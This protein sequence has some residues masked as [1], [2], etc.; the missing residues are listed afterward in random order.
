MEELIE[1][2]AARGLIQPIGVTDLENG[3]YKIRWGMRRTLA[4]RHLANKT[5][6]AL[7]HGLTEGDETDDMARENF[8]R[9]QLSDAEEAR[10]FVQYMQEKGVSAS[11]T[12][13]RL[14]VSYNKVLRASCIM[15]GD[16]EVRAAFLEGKIKA[17]QAVELVQV[18]GTVHR[19]NML[20]HAIRG[21]MPANRLRLWREQL[22]RDGVMLAVEH[23]PEIV[24][25][26]I[27]VRNAMHQQCNNCNEWKDVS[28]VPIQAI[29]NSCWELLR[30][31]YLRY[32]E[33][34]SQR[35]EK[36]GNQEETETVAEQASTHIG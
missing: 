15:E 12:A 35:E 24:A 14:R 26:A 34:V 21:E 30:D 10:F 11:E 29:C 27:S 33:A 18:E 16:E 32:T 22:E 13:R 1:D 2:I 9:E 19:Q 28:V 20:Y 17:A 3:W 31:L 23:V 4:H 7:V 25:Q 5:I 6:S 8:Q 36:N